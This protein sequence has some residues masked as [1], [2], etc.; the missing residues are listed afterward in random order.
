MGL[1]RFS[2][3]LTMKGEGPFFGATL[4]PIH[5][6]KLKVNTNFRNTTPF[7]LNFKFDKEWKG[8][9]VIDLTL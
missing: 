8:D 9:L 5:T 6:F 1:Y 3:F 7:P 2:Q 4:Y